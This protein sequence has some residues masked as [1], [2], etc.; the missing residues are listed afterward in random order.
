MSRETD[1]S[2]SGANGRGSTAYPSGTPPYGTPMATEAGAEAARSAAGERPEGPKT[3][4]TLTTRVRINIPGSRPIPPVVVRKPVGDGEGPADDAGSESETTGTTAM[5]VLT[6][7]PAP[8]PEPSPAADD[9]PASDWFAPRK[10]GG[11][12]NGAGFSAGAAA[13]AG[14]PAPRPGGGNGAGRPPGAPSAQPGGPRPGAGGAPRPG[15]TNGAGLPGA[16][17]AGP[18]APGHG[19][20]T[21]SFDVSAA[22][23]A[24]TSDREDLPYF[25]GNGTA[26]V[27]SGPTGGPVTGESPLGPPAT[28]NDPFGP[29]ADFTSPL[30]ADY[31]Q[32]GG[33]LSDDTAVLT[34][35]RPADGSGAPGY[36]GPGPLDNPSGH[37]LTSGIP[38]VPPG[39]QGAPFAPGGVDG[40]TRHTPPKLPDPGAQQQKPA[41]GKAPK[42]AKPAKKKGRSKLALL[43]GGVVV[44][45]GGVYGAGLLM[46][47]S[48][49][50]KGTTVLGV[51]IGGG[52]RDEAVNKLDKAFGAYTN[53]ELKLTVDG[54]TV[55]LR[56]DQA[57]LQFDMQDTVRVAAV[58][59]YNPVSVIG[60]L[61]GQKRVVEPVMPVDSEKLRAA[62]E[63]AAGSS[64]SASDGT[65]KF[66]PGKAV[67]VYGKA[68]KGL[69]VDQS[70]DAVVKAYRTQVETG[71]APAVSLP[72]TAKEPSVDKAEV[73]RFMK[74]FAQ[75]AMSGL[76]TVRTDAAH[77]VSFS[78]E[79]SI[80]KFLST[81]AVGGKLVERY[82]L[83]VLEDLFGGAFDGVTITKG[84]GSKK[85]VSAQDVA[86]A[87]GKALRG[88]K[89]ADRIVTIPLNPQ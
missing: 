41:G 28:P 87:L 23:A 17:G 52:T 46:N 78:P 75:P 8:V 2:S 47:H 58:S 86:S 19:G 85:P 72:T 53:K 55:T 57:G 15:G 16:T 49:V 68:G 61:F 79:R 81:R 63:R 71:T 76:V 24:A 34:P 29:A 69:A 50:P 74:E 9:K 37:T 73:D 1:T 14:G 80:Y 36:G 67:P 3:E 5:P 44:L 12:S 11:H 26:G 42:A 6:N 27:P 64:G 59:D 10:S 43:G 70:S 35:Q 83:A 18:V 13:A 54:G 38:V 51:D 65:V 89:P 21:G 84:D 82:D 48:D 25:S 33:G 66:E 77:T 88:Q 62:L 40:A 39:T 30:G 45:A 7:T 4:T 60:S 31:A 20:G 22:L 56:P 32:P